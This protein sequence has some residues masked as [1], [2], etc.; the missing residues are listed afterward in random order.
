[1]NLT[2]SAMVDHIILYFLQVS[3]LQMIL[4]HLR[5]RNSIQNKEAEIK[6]C[7]CTK[8]LLRYA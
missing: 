7:L 3:T 1:M 8:M 5:Y 6:Y 2:S 4:L